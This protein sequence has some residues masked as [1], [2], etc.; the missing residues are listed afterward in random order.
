MQDAPQ[1]LAP[2]DG[3]LVRVGVGGHRFDQAH[4]PVRLHD[5]GSIRRRE[6]PGGTLHFY[7]RKAA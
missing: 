1:A 3:A 6:R 7:Y 4:R 2:S 5:Q